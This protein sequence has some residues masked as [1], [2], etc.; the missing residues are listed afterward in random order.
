MCNCGTWA[1]VHKKDHSKELGLLGLTL[2]FILLFSFSPLVNCSGNVFTTMTGEVESPNYPSPYPES[3]RCDY[4]IQLEEG[5]RVVVT[6][7]RE[8]FD[9]EP[10]DSEGHCPDSLL[11]RDGWSVFFQLTQREF[12]L[13]MHYLAFC[14]FFFSF[15]PSY[16]ILLLSL[17]CYLFLFVLSLF[18][19]PHFDSL[20]FVAGDQ[21]FGPYC[22]NGFPGPLT[23]EIQSSALN[24]IF[25]TDGSEQRKGWKFRYH[26]DHE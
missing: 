6:M 18:W 5:F 8:D 19:F 25:Q 10:A 24:I 13:T 20:Q 1:S 16:F 22:G 26:G 4:Q 21:H 7:R 23:I 2:Y 12:S 3:S 11:V 15:S 9:V 14:P 17:P